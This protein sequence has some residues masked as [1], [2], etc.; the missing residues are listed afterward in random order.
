MFAYELA[1]QFLFPDISLWQ[2]HLATIV[3]TTF[4][5]VF[6]VYVVDGRLR[7]RTDRRRAAAL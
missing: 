1:K 5:A 7:T 4:L 3:F 2:S 6:A